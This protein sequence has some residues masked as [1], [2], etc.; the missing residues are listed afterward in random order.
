MSER[1]G[2]FEK[3]QKMKKAVSKSFIVY[4]CEHAQM[5]AGAGVELAAH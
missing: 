1:K 4:F 3:V 2:Y 5:S